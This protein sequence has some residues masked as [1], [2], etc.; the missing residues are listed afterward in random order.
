MKKILIKYSEIALKGKN[1]NDFVNRLV[2]NI[3]K[4]AN[5]FGVELKSIFKE[6][7]RIIL[8]YNTNNVDD[9]KKIHDSLSKTFGIK[10]FSFVENI[11]KTIEAVLERGEEIIL[12]HKKNGVKRIGFKTKR[13][14]KTF[15]ITSPEL[16]SLLGE[17]A[18]NNGIK[19]DYRNPEE[20]IYIEINEK[21]CFIY[22][23]KH[24]GPS[25]L[26][27]ENSKKVLVLLS[28]GI[29]S[30]VASTEMMKRGCRVDYLHIHSFVKN[31]FVLN[32]KIKDIV[33]KLNDYG[34]KSKLYLMPYSFYELQTSGKISHRFE[35]IFFKYYIFKLAEK[36]CDKYGYDGIVSGDNIN[37]VASQTLNNLKCVSYGIN[38]PI[39]RPL[40]TYEKEEII[41]KAIK[42][43]TFELSNIEYK[44]CCSIN[45]K[46]PYTQANLD[47]F[48]DEVLNKIN[49]DELINKSLEEI[50]EFMM[51]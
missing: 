11:D 37:Q 40:L 46:N 22:S 31:D 1:R 26:P 6:Y 3:S 39:F 51:K 12:E 15:P 41:N 28:G 13:N 10:Y 24:R 32:S 33:D 18:N 50:G 16:N 23:I 7:G 21:D 45:A 44:D 48:K 2:G 29:D 25:G 38:I 8:T 4:S 30:P 9:E 14:D 43:G 5:R 42:I 20:M 47:R 35:L 27:I 49:V 17:I 36:L 34:Y 19:I